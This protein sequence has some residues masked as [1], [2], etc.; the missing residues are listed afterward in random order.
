MVGRLLARLLRRINFFERTGD[1]IML[2]TRILCAVLILAGYSNAARAAP[3]TNIYNT[4]VLNSFVTIG[5][6]NI[7]DPHYRI[8]SPVG[9]TDVTVI[10]TAFPIPPWLANTYGFGGSRWIG[11]SANGNGPAGPWIYRTIFTVPP[12][13]ILSTVNVTGDWATDDP[14]TDI[15]INGTPTGQTSGSFTS[16][17]PF[18]VTSGFIFGTNTLD[19]YLTNAGGPTGLRVDHIS[20]SFQIP[21]PTALALACGGMISGFVLRPRRRC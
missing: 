11:P 15:R 7:A 12:T 1:T 2:K 21:E 5:A 10:D 13:A 8:I 14:G 9:Y 4:G 17:T 6:G 20:G 19:F 3:I 18:S 16:L